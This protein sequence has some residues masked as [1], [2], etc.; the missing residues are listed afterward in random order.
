VQHEGSQRKRRRRLPLVL[1][2][3][4]LLV[5]TAEA[6]AATCMYQGG[7]LGS[8]H[9]P[10][11]WD[12][13]RVPDTGDT[14]VVPEFTEVSVAADAAAGAVFL[15]GPASTLTFAGAATLA[16]G[17]LEVASATLQGDG[18][19]PP[20]PVPGERRRPSTRSPHGGSTSRSRP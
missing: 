17:T 3:G 7:N 12:C 10:L 4:W 11:H 1:T 5:P 16:T 15:G 18:L 19:R 9:E 20:A 14:A 6:P 13:G 8:W 2:L